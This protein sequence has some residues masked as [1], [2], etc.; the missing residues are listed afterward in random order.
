MRFDTIKKPRA[1]VEAA[2][3]ASG[4]CCAISSSV[5]EKIKTKAYELYQQRGGNH[6][7]DWEDWFLAKE[8]VERQERKAQRK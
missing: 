2:Q 3:K 5:D 7:R 6:G 4:P 1:T 8:L